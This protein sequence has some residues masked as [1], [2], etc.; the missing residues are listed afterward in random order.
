MIFLVIPVLDSIKKIQLKSPLFPSKPPD[1]SRAGVEEVPELTCVKD[2]R[3]CDAALRKASVRKTE[4]RLRQGLRS[5]V[6]VVTVVIEIFDR[7][8]TFPVYSEF[9][10]IFMI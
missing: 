1:G 5:V 4:V 9:Y 7:F 2:R 8:L 10:Q 3:R 6:I